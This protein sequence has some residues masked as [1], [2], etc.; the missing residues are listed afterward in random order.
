MAG[1]DFAAL[2][3]PD[4]R[5]AQALSTHVGWN[6]T[7]A[8]WRRLLHL[9]PDQGVA[10]RVDG[11]LVA[12][13]TLASYGRKVHWIGMVIVHE[14]QRGQGLGR[15]VLQRTLELGLKHGGT[16][17]L[18][19]TDLGRPLYRKSG[20]EDICAVDRWAGSLRDVAAG[21]Q[22]EE[23]NEN[24][25]AE[26]AELD[27]AASGV[28][29]GHLL[30]HLYSEQGVKAWF[31][32]GDTQ[33][34]GYAVLRPG[35]RHWQLGPLVAGNGDEFSALLNAAAAYLGG[36]PVLMDTLRYGD[37]LNPSPLD[38]AVLLVEAGLAVQRRLSRMSYGGREPTLTGSRI[39]LATGLEWG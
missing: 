29:R 13:A 9:N 10:A 21:E 24:R 20:F 27:A 4:V 18:D 38:P 12:T 14:S 23:A 19:A 6:Q 35:R 33:A 30:R 7:E 3:E 34:S 31:T 32:T 1:V 26:L 5:E 25:L 22:A 11:E 2:T 8:D 17:G 37:A 36:E 16:V 15:E 39:V 28:E